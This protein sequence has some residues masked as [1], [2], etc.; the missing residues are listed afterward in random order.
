MTLFTRTAGALVALALALPATAGT[1]AEGET[2]LRDAYGAYR[3]ALFLSNQGKAAETAQALGKFDAAWGALATGWRADP[4]PQYAADAQLGATLDTVA[5]LSAKAGA[6]VAEGKLPQAHEV[7]EEVRGEIAGLHTRAGLIG[8]SDRMNA[9]HAEMEA[10]LARDYLAL[11]DRAVP[12]AI[13]DAAVLSYLAGDIAA[14][15]APEAAQQGY[16]ELIAGFEA[17]VAD[18][19]SAA[20][21]GDPAAIKAA[22]GKLKVPYSKLF[23]KFG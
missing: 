21:G 17:S 4:P 23:A 12:T 15:P 11:G 1:F 19:V 5:A 20:Q 8:F 16:A 10:V 18:F 22:Q 6:A 14:N 3:A 7:L 2:T 13:A 9:Y